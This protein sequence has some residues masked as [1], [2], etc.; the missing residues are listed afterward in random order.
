M[1]SEVVDLF[2]EL[3]AI[4][5]P[6]GEERPVADVVAR[7][8]R[9][10][11]LTVDEDDAGAAVGSNAG[12][13]YCRVEP[14][15]N[16][17]GTPIFLCAHLDTV[18]PEGPLEPMIEDGVVR[19]AG[20]T[21]L[22]ADNKSAVAAMLEGTRRVLA[23]NRRHAGIELLFTPKE[24]VGLLGAAAF[25][26][27]RLAARVGYVYDQA[28]PI[29]DVILGAPYSQALEVRFHGR[30]AHSGMYPEEG[31]SAVVAAARAI[32]DLRLGR[33][34]DETTANVGLIEGGSAGN[35]VPEWCTLSAE[36]RS[37]DERKLS[38]LVQEMVDAFAFAAG[39]E[40]CEVEAKVSKSYRGYRFKRED[41]V[42]RLAHAALE[43]SGYTPSYGLSGGA[44]D[45]NVFNE[46][47]LACLNLANGMQDIHTPD[48]R[49][50]VDDLEGMVEVTLALVDVARDA[51]T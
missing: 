49:I 24:E 12:N 39:L 43:R 13:L 19:N 47:G 51:D 10:L 7:Y 50:T 35:I 1:P 27:R 38:E 14:N 23:E 17:G 33:V 41:E 8:L 44:A 22:G 18:P 32:S 9:D 5:S 6:P 36:A 40:D 34:D 42:V 30:A 11:G 28:A 2:T 37:H 48:E 15:G 20:G 26:H 4:S 21:I 46:R 29:G 31:R 45:A 3:A 25:D 16:G